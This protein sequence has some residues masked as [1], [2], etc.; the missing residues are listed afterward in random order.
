MEQFALRKLP[1][2]LKQYFCLILLRIHPCPSVVIAIRF[3]RRRTGRMRAELFHAI[4]DVKQPRNAR[5]YRRA[6]RPDLEPAR[7]QVAVPVQQNPKDHDHLQHRRDFAHDA[8]AHD[9]LADGEPDDGNADEQ[10]QIAS[11]DGAR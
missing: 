8:R 10:Q 2:L 9:H 3:Y 7:I 5:A 6:Q 4:P 11:D 1:G